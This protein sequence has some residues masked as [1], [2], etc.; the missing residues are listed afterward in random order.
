MVASKYTPFT[1]M[2][3]LVM[4]PAVEQYAPHAAA[5]L[6]ALPP[7]FALMAVVLGKAAKRYVKVN[8]SS[9]SERASTN[10]G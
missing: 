9:K 4:H 8:A 1:E 2:K 7:I 10:R 6:L 3:D 5:K